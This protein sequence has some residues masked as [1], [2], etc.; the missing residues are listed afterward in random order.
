MIWVLRQQLFQYTKQLSSV[1]L[2]AYIADSCTHNR[3]TLNTHISGKFML[4]MH[5]GTVY[6]EKGRLVGSEIRADC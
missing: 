3:L 1:R 5:S 6:G 2:L 4:T